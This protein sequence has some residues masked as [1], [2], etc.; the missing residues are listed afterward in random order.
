MGVRASAD[1]VAACPEVA[2]TAKGEPVT[3]LRLAPAPM[4]YTA[5]PNEGNTTFVVVGGIKFVLVV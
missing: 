5:I 2:G 1:G 4:A 3:G